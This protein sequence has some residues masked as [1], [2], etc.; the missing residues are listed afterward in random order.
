MLRFALGQ[1]WLCLPI[2]SFLQFLL[3]GISPLSDSNVQPF[4]RL[5]L[6]NAFN[7][8]YGIPKPSF[9]SNRCEVRSGMIVEI[10]PVLHA[11]ITAY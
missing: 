10:N 4:W 8:L 5:T 3:S 7:G 9:L 6:V 2:P 11:A 1:I